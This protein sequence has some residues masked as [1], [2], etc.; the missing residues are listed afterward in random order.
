MFSEE[1]ITRI[2]KA[3]W[4]TQLK[5]ELQELVEEDL[6]PFAFAE[7]MTLTAAIQVTGDWRGAVHLNSSHKLIRRAAAIMFS[8]PDH[9]LEDFHICDALGELASMTAGNLV[10]LLSGHFNLSLPFIV[11]GTFHSVRLLGAELMQEVELVFDGEAVVVAIL[12]ARP[13]KK[14]NR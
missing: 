9:A 8:T 10:S 13:D 4:S 5:L 3:V 14:R 7:E 2:T 11:D 1:E 12:Q 6:D